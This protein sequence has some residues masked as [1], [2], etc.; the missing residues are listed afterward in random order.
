MLYW[1]INYKTIFYPSR[2]IKL[3]DNNTL[4]KKILW[5]KI[6][7]WCLNKYLVNKFYKKYWNNIRIILSNTLLE[8]RKNKYYSF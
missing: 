3:L 2:S 6:I 1:N 7:E 8:Q 5:I 4:M